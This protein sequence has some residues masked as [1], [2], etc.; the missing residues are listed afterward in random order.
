[1][2]MV[3]FIMRHFQP[4]PEFDDSRCIT[5]FFSFFFFYYRRCAT[6]INIMVSFNG[7]AGANVED[8][9]RVQPPLSVKQLYSR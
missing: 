5:N 8:L 9:P 2:L 3:P 4:H 1:M 6:N 7:S